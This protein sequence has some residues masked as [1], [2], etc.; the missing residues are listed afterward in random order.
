MLLSK[1]YILDEKLIRQ[2]KSPER[3]AGQPFEIWTTDK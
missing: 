1:G 3:K 2:I